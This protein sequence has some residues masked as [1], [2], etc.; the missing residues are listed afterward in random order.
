M[1]RGGSL[2]AKRTRLSLEGFR[3]EGA[4]KPIGLSGRSKMA[5]AKFWVGASVPRR[6]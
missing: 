1:D 6:P 5:R 3:A 4:I 2:S